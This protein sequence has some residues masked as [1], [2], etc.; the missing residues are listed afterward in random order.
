MV[1]ACL[2]CRPLA[3]IGQ[4]PYSGRIQELCRYMEE[5]SDQTLKLTDLA[6]RAGLSPFHLQRSFKAA[7]GVSPKEYFEAVRLR[8]LKSSLRTSKDVTEAVYDA[9]YGSSSRVYERADTR[10]GMTPLQYRHGGRGVRISYVSIQS[11][12]GLMMIGATDRGLCFVQFGESQSAL[13]KALKREYEAAE[14]EEMRKPYSEEF[15]KRN[16]TNG[17]TR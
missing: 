8:K 9:G 14:L 6:K 16:F 15:H 11:P 1:R 2:R 3:A 13:L 17:S 4:D 12:V 10:L 5:N 7:I